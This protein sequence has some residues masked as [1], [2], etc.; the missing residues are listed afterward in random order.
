MKNL[1]DLS[2]EGQEAQYQKLTTM[3][4]QVY[5]QTEDTQHIQADQGKTL[6]NARQRLLLAT[7]SV[8]QETGPVDQECVLQVHHSS[9]VRFPQDERDGTLVS[10]RNERGGASHLRDLKIRS[11]KPG[12]LKRIV[13]TLAAAV[14]LILIVLLFGSAIL[15]LRQART[16]TSHQHIQQGALQGQPVQL[17]DISGNGTSTVVNHI[18]PMS[19]Q[20]LWHFTLKPV[21]ETGGR[22][23]LDDP[24]N[25]QAVKGI[26]YFLGTDTAG[27]S[28]YAINVTTGAL[29]WKSLVGAA[30]AG[31][32]VTNGLVYTAQTSNGNDFM[33]ALSALTGQTVWKRHF[34]GSAPDVIDT[35]QVIAATSSV[36][37]AVSYR[38]AQEQSLLYALDA[39]TG[40]VLW[41][42]QVSHPEEITIGKIVGST[43]YLAGGVGPGD[44][45]QGTSIYAYDLSTSTQLWT[46]AIRGSVSTLEVEQHTLYATTLDKNSRGGDLPGSIYVLRPSDGLLLWQQHP[47]SVLGNLLIA[48]GEVYLVRYNGTGGSTMQFIAEGHGKYKIIGGSTWHLEALRGSD[49]HLDWQQTLS[50][51]MGTPLL[52]G[53]DL[54]LPDLNGTI[55]VLDP[56]NGKQI[57]TIPISGIVSS[58]ALFVA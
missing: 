41:Q 48:G 11:A 50:A 25:P 1:E 35:M 9:M 53:S 37:Y 57:K 17:Y 45:G 13:N 23:G 46:T 52:F 31:L 51:D 42:K 2:F 58:I 4:Q 27:M 10:L 47:N 20:V 36:L 32:V 54:Y 18:D 30:G 12:R 38:L 55:H 24:E 8:A 6:T 16:H 22:L 49:G 56:S 14:S 40:Q 39:Q 3:L 43:L 44:Q 5:Q 21:A 7:S 19:G 29:V 34:T 33:L 15:A 26:L 28:V